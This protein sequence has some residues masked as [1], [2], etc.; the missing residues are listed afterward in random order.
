[1]ATMYKVLKLGGCECVFD[2]L[3]TTLNT[4]SE[5]IWEINLYKKLVKVDNMFA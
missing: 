2:V 5:N 4:K 3:G 1:M